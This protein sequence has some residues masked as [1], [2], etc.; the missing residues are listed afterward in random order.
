MET[1]GC[2]DVY[3]WVLE[4]TANLIGT[5]GRSGMI[6]PLSLGFSSKFDVCRKF[7]FRNYGQNWFSSFG[8]IPDAL[9]GSDVR[10]RNT[11]HLGLRTAKQAFAYSSRLHRWFREERATLFDSIQYVRFQPELWNYHV[12]KLNTQQ[13]AKAFEVAMER[14]KVLELTLRRQSKHRLF[15]KQTA[16]NWLTVCRELPPCYRGENQVPHS[17]VGNLYFADENTKFPC[18]VAREWQAYVDILAMYRRR[19]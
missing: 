4:R 16:Y 1:Q 11:V 5:N 2:P 8:R 19:L 10:V 9:F 18:D 13:L 17:K 15:F 3:A 6:V 14:G 7:L 12:P